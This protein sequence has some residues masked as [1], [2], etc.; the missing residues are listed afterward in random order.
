MNWKEWFKAVKN[1]T[2]YINENKRSYY[3]DSPETIY[4]VFKA[5]LMDETE[6]KYSEEVQAWKLID[7]EETQS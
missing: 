1:H 5:R 7:T 3:E 2:I 4:Q 6:V